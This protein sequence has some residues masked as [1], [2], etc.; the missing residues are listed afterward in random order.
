MNG[1]LKYSSIGFAAALLVLLGYGVKGYL[2]ADADAAA[3]G[4]RADALI[5]RGL[6]GRDLGAERL[7]RLLQVEDPA[8]AEHA[9]VDFTTDGAGATTVSQSVSKRLAFERFRPGLGKIRQTGYAL[10]LERNL[11]KDQ[12]LALWLDT[13]EMGRGPDGW[14]TGFDI[15]SRAIYGRSPKDVSETEFLRLVAVVIAPASFD[16]QGDDPELDERVERI[17]RLLAGRC[18]QAGHGDVWLEG[19]RL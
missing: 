15:A 14:M 3:L 19:C 8:F 7:R 10:G 13:L 9:G 6:G 12:I 5:A 4:E 16:L 18:A 17:E 11:T 1:I 2:D